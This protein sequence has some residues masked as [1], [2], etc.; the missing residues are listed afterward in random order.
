LLPIRLI[1]Q[2]CEIDCWIS[3]PSLFLQEIIEGLGQLTLDRHI[4]HTLYDITS[5]D[6]PDYLII[7]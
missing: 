5:F 7:E 2:F 6:T 4:Q 1:D 3:V